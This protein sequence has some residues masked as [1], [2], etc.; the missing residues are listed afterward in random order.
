LDSFVEVNFARYF[1]AREHRYVF[2]AEEQEF[3]L[4][5]ETNEE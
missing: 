1:K 3:V 2:D 5:D 4:T